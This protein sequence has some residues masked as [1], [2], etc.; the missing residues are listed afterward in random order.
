MENLGNSELGLLAEIEILKDE[1]SC[2]KPLH[3]VLIPCLFGTVARDARRFK[4]LRMVGE[5]AVEET[6]P[7]GRC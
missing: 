7:F 6:E 1:I 4:R 5:E 2:E 3:G